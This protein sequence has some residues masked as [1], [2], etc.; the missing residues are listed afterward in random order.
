MSHRDRP[1]S[2]KRFPCPCCGY[3]TL[4]HEANGSYD[5]CPVCFWED[6]F[7]QL[8]DPTYRGGANVPSLEEARR[9]FL[10]FG[11]MEERFR[12]NV[13]PPFPDE[14]PSSSEDLS[15]SEDP[16]T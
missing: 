12:G 5:L 1:V 13:R 15:S 16:S 8:E 7:Q 4:D 11:A 14:D 6:D 2:A 3:L 10:V 9:N